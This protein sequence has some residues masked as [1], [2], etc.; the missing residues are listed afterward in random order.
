MY[1]TKPITT[2]FYTLMLTLACGVAHAQIQ[3]STL[4][5]ETPIEAF[6]L[7]GEATAA[8]GIEGTAL[9]TISINMEPDWYVYANIPGEMGKPTKLTATAADG[10]A[11]TV[12]YP[13][14]KEKPDTFDPSVIINAYQS[15]TRL[16]ILVPAD[17]AAYPIAMR[18]DLL[19]CHPTKCIPVRRD[20]TFGENGLDV[21]GFPLAENQPWWPGFV[22]LARK[23]TGPS[24]SVS[25]T[26]TQESQDGLE[27]G[28]ASCRE[29]VCL[30]G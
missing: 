28:R 3:P 30:Y 6:K 5:M 10:T 16:F 29:R 19:L 25:S 2:L 15:G 18:L 14:G 24:K 4:P 26:A 20:L 11:L 12:F 21:S 7:T 22:E 9:L 27:I 1:L 8:L 13:K 23:D 17:V